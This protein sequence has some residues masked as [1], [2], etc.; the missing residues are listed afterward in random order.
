MNFLVDG[1]LG[2]LARWLR[3]LGHD[4]RYE[5]NATDNQLLQIAERENMIL[6]TRDTELS[7]R[8]KTRKL[9]SLLVV[10]ETEEGLAQIA[11]TF[12]IDLDATMT[13][14]KCPECGS[15][16]NEASK[17]EIANKVPVTSLKLYDKFWKCTGCGKVY[18][19]GSHWKRILQ[20]LGNAKEI[21][22][23]NT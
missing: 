2:G 6:L 4:V 3:I 16:L 18:W 7:Q 9:S 14:T 12:G 19:L 15:S 21:V 8:A 11:R 20:T 13:T 17:T 23:S 1:M 5:S 10:G 22:G